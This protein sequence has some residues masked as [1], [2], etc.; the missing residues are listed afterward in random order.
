MN[1]NQFRPS[2]Q[3]IEGSMPLAAIAVAMVLAVTVALLL[4]GVPAYIFRPS[5]SE[6]GANRSSPPA[7]VGVHEAAEL[8]GIASGRVVPEGS[9]WK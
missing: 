2:S 7:L 6:V 9:A 5:H 4:A 8:A 1:R 3:R